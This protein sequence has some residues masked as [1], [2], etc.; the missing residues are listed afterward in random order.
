MSE[1][2]KSINGIMKAKM[3][4]EKAKKGKLMQKCPCCGETKEINTK[5]FY[6][7]Y[8][9]LFTNAEENRMFWCKDCVS[10]LYD[11]LEERYKYPLK[12]VYETCRMLDI[13][14]SKSIYN[15]SLKQIASSEKYTDSN[16]FCMYMKVVNSLPQCKG[17]TFFD[18]DALEEDDLKK[19]KE[20]YKKT[21]AYELEC[22][23]GSAHNEDEIEFLENHYN[24]WITFNDC[25]KL[26][27]QKLVRIICEKELAIEKAKI[28]GEDVTKLEESLLKIMDSAKLTPK[29]MSEVN[30]TE[31]QRVYGLWIADIEKYKPAEYFKDKSI[32]EDYDGILD[33]IKRF[34]F[35]PLKNLLT[36]T[37]EFDKEFNIKGNE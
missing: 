1:E 19:E 37:R 10:V 15:A 3:K 16:I 17:K 9:V 18:S 27:T 28:A 4:T 35:R 2:L 33:Y 7:S 11:C 5:N 25:S 36:G 21:L 12:A 23:W 8:S 34:V 13:F 32:Y 22:R 14:F 6:K 29:S 31:S 26:S 30:E 24:E 20:D